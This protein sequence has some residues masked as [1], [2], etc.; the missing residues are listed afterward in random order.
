M[1]SLPLIETDDSPGLVAG[2]GERWTQCR[3]YDRCLDIWI[4]SSDA[5]SLPVSAILW[6]EDDPQA[7]CHVACAKY[8]VIPIESRVEIAQAYSGGGGNWESIEDE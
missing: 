3:R 6:V 7:Q 8:S 2:T 5:W 4:E 1:R